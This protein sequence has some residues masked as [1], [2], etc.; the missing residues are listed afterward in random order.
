MKAAAPVS[1]KNLPALLAKLKQQRK[2]IVFTNGVFDIIHRGHI[3]YLYKA[4]SFG[5]ILIVGL[6]S[7]SSVRRLK[8]NKRPLQKQA[9]RAA[10]VVSLKPVDY[11]VFFGEDTPERLIEAIRPDILVKGADYKVREIVGARFVK[12]YGG[13]VRRV[14]LSA[15][16]SSSKLIKKL[17]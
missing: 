15:G 10:I 11:V 2:L 8:G 12:S 1:K 6:N 17:S 9:D 3:D 4:R 16:R 13:K 5:H 14:R 7:D